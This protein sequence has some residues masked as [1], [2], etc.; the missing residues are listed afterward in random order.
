MLS[1]FLSFDDFASLRD[2]Q[3]LIYFCGLIISMI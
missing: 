2:S 1:K 3:G